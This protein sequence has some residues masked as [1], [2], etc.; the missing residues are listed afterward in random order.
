MNTITTRLDS[1]K[2]SGQ[3]SWTELSRVVKMFRAPDPTQLNSS[4]QGFTAT[5][6]TIWLRRMLQ[7]STKLAAQ[8]PKYKQLK[9]GIK[10]KTFPIWET[11]IRNNVI[12]LRSKQ[13]TVLRVQDAPFWL[14]TSLSTASTF[15]LVQIVC[16][17]SPVYLLFANPS[18]QSLRSSRSSA[19]CHHC[20]SGNYFIFLHCAL[21]CAVYCNRPCL[22]VCFF[23]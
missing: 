7:I 21:S 13:R 5:L 14:E 2:L 12:A 15:S 20:L 23:V 3:L 1:I 11:R 8:F 9:T 19:E 22:F 16:F 4:E 6:I 10:S 17:L 18:R